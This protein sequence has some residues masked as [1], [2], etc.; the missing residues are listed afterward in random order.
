MLIEKLT[1][2]FDTSILISVGFSL[3]TF[4]IILLVGFVVGIILFF[5]SGQKKR[6]NLQ[7][8]L[9]IQ[10]K[11]QGSDTQPGGEASKETTEVHSPDGKMKISMQETLIG[12]IASYVF[13]VSEISGG[14][15]IE[16][17]SKT[18]TNGRMELSKNSWSPDNKYVFL[19]EKESEQTQY[20]VFRADGNAF[21]NGEKH[22]D[23]VSV[24]ESKKT[25]AVLSDVTGWDSPTLLHLLTNAKSGEEMNYW[26]EI[27]SKALIRLASR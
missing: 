22:I 27:P 25:G 8:P 23:V 17:F 24:F 1:S 9:F 18:L 21:S 10:T 4:A 13:L 26:F 16:I 3:R 6:E 15:N 14:N 19:R 12:E 7:N 5:W 2:V 11:V 20:Y